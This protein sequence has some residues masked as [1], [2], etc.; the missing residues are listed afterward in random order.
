MEKVWVTTPRGGAARTPPCLGWLSGG[1][2]ERSRSNWTRAGPLRGIGREAA[3]QVGRW[4]QSRKARWQYDPDLR[5]RRSA[6]ASPTSPWPLLPPGAQR[7]RRTAF[8][9][10][11]PARTARWLGAP[12]ASRLLWSS[13]PGRDC[14]GTGPPEHVPCRS[15]PRPTD[16]FQIGKGV[17]QGC[18]LSPCLFNLTCKVHHVECQAGWSISWNQDC[19]E[20]CQ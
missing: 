3:S 11:S 18:I 2:W 19:Q 5:A 9:A 12:G 14:R 15:V 20:K 7:A 10:P 1:P 8:C 17:R 4:E 13:E 16:W 6:P